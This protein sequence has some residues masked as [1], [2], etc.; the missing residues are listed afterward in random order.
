MGI[1]EILDA[2]FFTSI[3][4]AGRIGYRAYGVPLSGAADQ[5]SYDQANHIVGNERGTAILELTL[6]GGLYRFQ[7]NAIIALTGAKMSAVINKLEVPF[8]QQIAVKAGDVL[9]L[10][11]TNRGC[12]TYLAIAGELD[13]DEVMGS[14]ST[15]TTGKFGGYEGRPLRKGDVIY[16]EQSDS[17][18][19]I[20]LDPEEIP[21]FSSRI[22]L[23]ITKG[24]EWDWIPGEEQNQL[25][26]AT[27]RVA[28]DSNRMG[29]RLMGNPLRTSDREMR[30]SAVIPGIIQLPPNGNPIILMQDS[31]TIG[32]YPRIAKVIENDMWRLGQAKPGDTITFS[33]TY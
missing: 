25:L 11:F 1:L 10:G 17:H 29:V 23:K 30:S 19:T 8:Y 6:R 2:G 12:R 20:E 22:S 18:E 3:Q 26:A 21:Y 33:L 15:F 16:W 4:D 5:L 9:E 13:C 7:S 14:K 24:P 27:F 32:G 28:Q 31:Q